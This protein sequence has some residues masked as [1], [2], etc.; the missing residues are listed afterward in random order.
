M[1]GHGGCGLRV[2][3][4]IYGSEYTYGGRVILEVTWHDLDV[5]LREQVGH[6]RN[7]GIIF[8]W[9]GT[10]SSGISALLAGLE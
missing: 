9:I 1:R 6:C 8:H 3:V 2:R 5:D 4:G 7:C 10:F